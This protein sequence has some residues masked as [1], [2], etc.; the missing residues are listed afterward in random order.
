MFTNK[1]ALI[2]GAGASS[3]LGFPLGLDLKTKLQ[4]VLDIKF[5]HF[6]EQ[7]SGDYHI[8]DAL[9]GIVHEQGSG[10]INPYLHAG[11]AIRDAMPTTTSIDSFL[12]T[13][14]GNEKIIT[15]A[16]L[17]IAR[18]ILTAE[19]ASHIHQS[20]QS[21]QVELGSTEKT[22]YGDLFKLLAGDVQDPSSIFKNLVV[23]SFNYDRSLEHYL[24]HALMR[25]FLISS[26]KAEEIMASLEIYHPYG[27][28]GHLP[29]QN[30]EVSIPYGGS[31]H[32]SDLRS[33]I[34]DLR[35]FSEGVEDG[36]IGQVRLQLASA[37]TVLLIGFGYAPINMK[38]LHLGGSRDSKL[39]H[40]TAYGIDPGESDV[41]Q[42]A[43]ADALA[44]Q[45]KNVN[46][47][48]ACK[49]KALF[50]RCQITFSSL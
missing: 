28:V 26:H 19:R 10:D 13:H 27:V 32:S 47:H 3:E 22:W 41:L 16:K 42:K 25:R 12:Q 36:Y 9:R 7:F 50:E 39:V 6:S 18:S 21:N 8:V 14:N 1:V 23:V 34:K 37:S 11:W 24:C 2:V 45:I 17:G 30:R 44:A 4:K 49:C 5:R 31:D 33:A 43:I 46:V 38:L 15:M 29:W 48:V 20:Q 40:A 35:T